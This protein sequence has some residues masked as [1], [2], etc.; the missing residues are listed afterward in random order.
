MGSKELCKTGL[1]TLDEILAGGIPKGYTVL[2]AGSSGTGKTILT[3]E[4]LLKGAKLYNEPG[5]YISLSEAPKKMIANME[6]FNYYDPELIRFGMV[7]VVELKSEEGLRRGKTPDPEKILRTIRNLVEENHAKRL[8]IDS[9][10]AIARSIKD[11]TLIRDFIT[12][13]TDNLGILEC[14]SILI[15]EIKPREITYSVFGVEEFVSDGIILLG[16]FERKGDLLRTLQIIKMRGV[17]HPRSK[18]VM[19]ITKDGVQLMPMFKA[20]GE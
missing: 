17:D 7:K 12:D 20:Y 19:S 15:S 18:Q 10:T 14:T 13:L 4:I 5:I 6:N 1:K 11:E 16:E 3:Q 8:V 2:L 9:I